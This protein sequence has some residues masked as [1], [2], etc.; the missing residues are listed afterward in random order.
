MYRGGDLFV[1]LFSLVM[2]S[3]LS[4]FKL[5]LRPYDDF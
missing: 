2:D 1:V 5:E 3:Q 4:Y